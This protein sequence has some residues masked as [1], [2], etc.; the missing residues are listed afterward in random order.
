MK[1]LTKSKMHGHW[2]VKGKCPKGLYGWAQKTESGR[3]YI[4]LH[5]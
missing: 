1:Y 2:M 4:E 5:F 3:P